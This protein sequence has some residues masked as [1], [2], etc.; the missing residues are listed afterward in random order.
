MVLESDTRV[1]HIGVNC[2][3]CTE[4]ETPHTHAHNIE[5]IECLIKKT[6]EREASQEERLTE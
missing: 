4:P 3:C 6:T 2:N 1:V 5:H